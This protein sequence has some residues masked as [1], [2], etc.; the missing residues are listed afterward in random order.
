[1]PPHVSVPLLK[2]LARDK[3]LYKV[4]EIII[5]EIFF[6]D[7]D[8]WE[9]FGPP[10]LSERLQTARDVLANTV[11]TNMLEEILNIILEKDLDVEPTVRYLALQLLLVTGV[12]SLAV[13]NFP[14]S[15]YSLVLEAIA[16]SCASLRKLDLKG[17][18]IRPKDKL[19]FCKVVRRLHDVRHLT[20]KYV[21]DDELLAIIG[22]HCRILERLDIS[23][24]HNISEEGIES[25]IANPSKSLNG[26]TSDVCATLQII[27]FGG[28]GAQQLSP[29]LGTKLLLSLPKL[30]SLG[31]FEKTGQSL[32]LIYKD[33]PNKTV[34]L[35][36]IHDVKTNSQ[37]LSIIAKMCPDLQAVYLDCPGSVAVQHLHMLKKMTE[38]K[39][40]KAKW[41]DIKVLIESCGTRLRSIFLIT[42][43]GPLN[44]IDLGA[45][46]PNLIRLELHLVSLLCS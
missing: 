23:G 40:H 42:V 17:L 25:F 2:E 8:D 14:E 18:W 44:F 46:C 24:S 30:I 7:D 11:S 43:W 32:E 31:S 22:K 34:G 16:Q 19:A 36:Y 35:R 1:M 27:D 20:V 37:R 38:V 45:Q 5:E 29:A 15:Y 41:A 39:L 3:V 13:G 6:S 21:C 9:A 10:V 33:N 26:F 28:P 4:C 12:S